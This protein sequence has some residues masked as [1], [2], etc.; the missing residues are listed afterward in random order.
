MRE[1]ESQRACALRAGEP[2]ALFQ[3]GR[4]LLPF[5]FFRPPFTP[6]V[7]LMRYLPFLFYSFAPSAKA[8]IARCFD[9]VV[10]R[11]RPLYTPLYF[12]VFRYTPYTR[13]L[14]YVETPTTQFNTVPRRSPMVSADGLQIGYTSNSTERGNLCLLHFAPV[15]FTLLRQIA[16]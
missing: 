15:D 8:V 16:Q 10:V 3:H 7:P 2:L 5:A 6:F 4:G 13:A 12:R 1:G 14:Y 11:G 9:L